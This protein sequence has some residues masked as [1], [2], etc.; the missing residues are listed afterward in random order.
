MSPIAK[1]LGILVESSSSTNILPLEWT[2]IPN[3]FAPNYSESAFLPTAHTTVS[4]SF[5]EIVYSV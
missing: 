2:F 3:S 5:S 1:M 4:N